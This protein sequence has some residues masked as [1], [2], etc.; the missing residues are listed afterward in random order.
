MARFT[1]TI[2]TDNAAFGDSPEERREEISRIL[3]DIATTIARDP[4]GSGTIWDANG[5]NVG[6]YGMSDD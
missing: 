6:E 3:R 2:D 5:N 4:W 1:L